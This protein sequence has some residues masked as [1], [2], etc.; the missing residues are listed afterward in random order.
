VSGERG[1]ADGRSGA[2]SLCLA[3]VGDENLINNIYRSDDTYRLTA[4]PPT[5]LPAYP[6]TRLPA[7]L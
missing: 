1:K 5:R 4:Y 7:Y 6:P 2:K 3:N